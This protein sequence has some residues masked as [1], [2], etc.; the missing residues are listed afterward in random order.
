MRFET[1]I[2]DFDGTL[3]DT[4]NS[5][6]L[7][8]RETLKYLNLPLANEEEIKKRI[9]LPLKTTF[10]DIAGLEGDNLENAIKEY[11]LRYDKI[12]FETVTLFPGVRNTLEFFHGKGIK[13]GVASSKGKDSLALLLEHLEIASLFSFIGGEQD[14]SNKKPAPDIVN[15]AIK[16][17]H[18]TNSKSL[19][20]G[21][22]I[23]DI[24]MGRNAGCATCA[25]TYGNNTF[26]ELNNSSPNFIVNEFPEL[27][28]VQT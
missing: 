19:V 23:Y 16:K 1:L 4:K 11:R 17:L 3:A 27:L 22:T 9:G 14:V 8:V 28:N 20:I 2:L 15:L 7:T 12:S 13:L 18:A 25:V 26:E 10:Q 6:I 5:I 24:Q 21:D